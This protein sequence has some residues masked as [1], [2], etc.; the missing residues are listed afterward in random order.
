MMIIIKYPPSHTISYEKIKLAKEGDIIVLLQDG[1]LYAL[2]EGLIKDLRNHGIEVKV[3]RDD[4]ICRGYSEGESHADLI[5]YEEFI[6]LI[7]D[8]GERVIG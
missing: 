5:G 4:F 6:D 2:D 7:A 1:V 3:L 8:K